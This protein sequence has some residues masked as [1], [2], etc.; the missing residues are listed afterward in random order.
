[1]KIFPKDKISPDNGLILDSFVF[2]GFF[3]NR[4]KRRLTWQRSTKGDRGGG[5]GGDCISGGCRGDCK[6]GESGGGDDFI[7]GGGGDF[8][9]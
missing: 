6:D 9:G 7:D 3:L 4:R 8:D 2:S 1:M 5:G